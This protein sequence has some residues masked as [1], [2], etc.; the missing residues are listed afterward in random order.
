MCSASLIAILYADSLLP[1]S[2]KAK[3]KNSWD[4]NANPSSLRQTLKVWLEQQYCTKNK[5]D[6]QQKVQCL[7][8]IQA[9]RK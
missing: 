2:D 1:L 6:S 9:M 5:S 8:K 4:Q 3:S 7:V